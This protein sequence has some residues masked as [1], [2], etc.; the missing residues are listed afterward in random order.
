MCAA[1]LEWPLA[2]RMA[3]RVSTRVDLMASSDTFLSP[4]RWSRHLE[5]AVFDP[6]RTA[7]LD[8]P[9]PDPSAPETMK[10]PI[11]VERS[12]SPWR[13]VTERSSAEL[14]GPSW[15]A[16]K[17]TGGPSRCPRAL[18]WRSSTQPWGPDTAI[19]TWWVICWRMLQTSRPVA[20]P[21][22]QTQ[23]VDTPWP[24]ST[25][26]SVSGR[27]WT[28][29]QPG[30]CGLLADGREPTWSPCDRTTWADVS[31]FALVCTIMCLPRP[32]CKP[33]SLHCRTSSKPPGT[34]DEAG[35]LSQRW[36]RP[37]SPELW[38]ATIFEM[39]T[40][41]P[42]SSVSLTGL[43]SPNWMHLW[44][45]SLPSPWWRGEN[46]TG[47]LEM[48]TRPPLTAPTEELWS[49]RSSSQSSGTMLWWP[50]TGLDEDGVFPIVPVKPWKNLLDCQML[51]GR[52]AGVKCPPWSPVLCTL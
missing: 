24:S 14:E 12:E 28:G 23:V 48:P 17:H 39:L 21:T 11:A 52:G 50:T 44:R 10:L 43:P 40:T 46:L 19:Q 1:S 18:T 36:W 31:S 35:S 51:E 34:S 41:V 15:M 2:L 42:V 38:C 45:E 49:R 26:C 6:R 13:L 3:R 9:L 16:G 4:R 7:G 8:L 32:W 5:S 37:A 22:W 30:S 33:Q 27:L 25:P 29:N 47:L 20:H